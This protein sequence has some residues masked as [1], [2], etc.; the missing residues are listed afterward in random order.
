M[1]DWSRGSYIIRMHDIIIVLGV[2]SQMCRLRCDALDV[3][4][5]LLMYM[6]ISDRCVIVTF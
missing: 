4:V 1:R 6:Y 2:L 3:L 5:V